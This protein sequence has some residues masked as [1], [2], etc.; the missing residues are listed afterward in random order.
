ME[1]VQQYLVERK[2]LT[3][4]L[5]RENPEECNNIS[6]KKK[7]ILDAMTLEE[8]EELKKHITPRE[9][10]Y[11]IK[12]RIEKLESNLNEPKEE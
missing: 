7:K 10:H 8:L 9:A 5:A 4:T 6:E 11:Q 1:K 2:K 12:P 3:F